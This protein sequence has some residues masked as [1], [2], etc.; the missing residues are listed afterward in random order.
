VTQEYEPQSVWFRSVSLIPSQA[1][2][3]MPATL[4]A[5][6]KHSK[7]TYF[8]SGPEQN[9]K[10][11]PPWGAPGARAWGCHHCI[12]GNFDS[13]SSTAPLPSATPCRGSV[14]RGTTQKGQTESI[15]AKHKKRDTIFVEIK[16]KKGSHCPIILSPPKKN[17][18][19]VY[20]AFEVHLGMTYKDSF[21]SF[22]CFWVKKSHAQRF[23]SHIN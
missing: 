4:G 11:L 22:A 19:G 23:W 21:C 16:V 15:S 14:G 18:A 12:P 17:N 9:R 7:S 2:L 5:C 20:F 1:G 3:V 6:Q 10:S 8:G 13:Q